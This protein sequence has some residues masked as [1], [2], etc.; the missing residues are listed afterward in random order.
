MA[1]LLAL[2]VPAVSNAA[3]S[4]RWLT[5]PSCTATTAA[6]TCTGKAAGVRPKFI[7]GLSAVTTGVQGE[8][9]YTCTDPVFETF[10][11]GSAL[12]VPLDIQYL[13]APIGDFRNGETFSVEFLPPPNPPGMFNAFYCLSGVWT[14]DPV[15]YNVRVVVG[16][17]FGSATPIEALEAAVGTVSPG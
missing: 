17:G 5:D 16:W 7:S 3:R 1:A 11:F 4:A 2:A 14:R 9:H 8:I 15:Y 12:P 10:F 6:L 13:A